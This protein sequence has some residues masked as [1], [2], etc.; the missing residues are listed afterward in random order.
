MVNHEQ[1]H[2]E[3]SKE[4]FAKTTLALNFATTQEKNAQLKVT[5]AH[6]HKARAEAAQAKAHEIL[7]IANRV[8]HLA[9]TNVNNARKVVASTK[10]DLI[11]AQK[12]FDLA[13]MK[14]EEYNNIF[15][16]AEAQTSQAAQNAKAA[17]TA[18]LN[19]Q[20]VYNLAFQTYT[21]SKK[22][23]SDALDKKQQADLVV[24]AARNALN[25]AIQVNDEAQADL[26]VSHDNYKKAYSALDNANA[27]VSKLRGQL[28]AAADMLGVAKFNLQ[29]SNNNLFVAQARKAEADKATE[30]VKS[31]SST[32]PDPNSSSTYIF[33]GC[34]QEG[35]PTVAGADIVRASNKLG[36][37]LR[38]G[39]T[40]LHGACTKATKATFT[41]G[42]MISY[43]GY[44]KNGYVHATHYH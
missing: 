37:K 21:K 3:D 28:Q 13:T 12:K 32:L 5:G 29:Q 17:L 41:E 1:Q 22:I 10:Q 30:M 23:L 11:I 8:V 43:T 4:H 20:N 34:D 33:E 27:L 15:I 25:L 35:Y 16:N 42:E 24:N 6:S 18:A 14:F 2:V 19:A 31:Q 26:T 38:S 40:L 39:Y 36:F 44:M 7:E 9:T